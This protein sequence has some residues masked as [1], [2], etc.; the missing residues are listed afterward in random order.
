VRDRPLI[1]G[2]LIV[3]IVLVTTPV[4]RGL[5]TP[6]VTLAAPE[7]KL[8]AQ[9]RECVAPV[10]YM[11]TSHM[12]LLEEWRDSVVRTGQRKYV[13]YNGKLYEKSLTQT[14]LSAC[15]GS[16]QEFC[17]RCHNYSGVSALNCWKCH[18]DAVQ[19]VRNSP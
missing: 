13:A 15:H 7:I 14:C 10:S 3:F 4:W 8:P 1:L 6:K 18:S 5:A 11:R 19:V 9:E 2:G 16:R 12:Q 17:D